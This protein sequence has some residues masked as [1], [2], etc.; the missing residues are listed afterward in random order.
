MLLL[1]FYRAMPQLHRARYWWQTVYRSSFRLSVTLRYRPY[2]GHIGWNSWKIIS[3]LN[4]LTFPLSEDPTSHTSKVNTP[5]FSRNMSR[6]GKIVDFRHLSHC[7]GLYLKRCKMSKLLGLYA[8]SI[9]TK[10]DDLEW[11]LSEIRGRFLKCRKN[12]ATQLSND[13]DAM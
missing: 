12:G 2:R 3:R 10:I 1:R 8:L 4:S 13:S 11:P 5:N 7:I 9:C 6:V